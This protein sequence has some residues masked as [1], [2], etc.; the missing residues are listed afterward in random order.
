MKF[1]NLIIINTDY[2]TVITYNNIFYDVF[3]IWVF[4]YFYL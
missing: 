1:P 3:V 4:T 2:N